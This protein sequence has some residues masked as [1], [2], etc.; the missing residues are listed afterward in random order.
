MQ[1]LPN[2]RKKLRHNVTVRM[3]CTKSFESNACFMS[4]LKQIFY[5]HLHIHRSYEGQKY[6]KPGLQAEKSGAHHKHTKNIAMTDCGYTV[7]SL[8]AAHHRYILFVFMVSSFFSACIPGLV[9]LG[10]KPSVTRSHGMHKLLCRK[11]VNKHHCNN[12]RKRLH[13]RVVLNYS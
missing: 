1:K 6:N 5:E 9:Y 10:P 13:L 7:S 11:I 4:G 3:N 12:T 8:Q 2:Q